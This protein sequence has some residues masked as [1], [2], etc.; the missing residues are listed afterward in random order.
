MAFT[1]T[2]TLTGSTFSGIGLGVIVLT[3]A[4]EAG[5]ASATVA[6]GG[7]GPAPNASLT[8]NGS[9]SA[10][11]WAACDVS[12]SFTSWTLEPNNSTSATGCGV[13]ASPNGETCGTYTGTVTAGTPVTVGASAPSTN[14]TPLSAYEIKASGTLAVDASTPAFSAASA[15]TITSPSFTPPGGVLVAVASGNCSA[16]SGESLAISDTSGL[17]LTWTRRVLSA[18][19]GTSLAWTAIWT[20]SLSTAISG[21]DSVTGTDAGPGPGATPEIKGFPSTARQWIYV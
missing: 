14:Y 6:G 3:G 15:N 2:V 18:T 8:P 9:G 12:G 11:Y 7:G 5:G 19:F 17:G 1:V 13:R 4:T 21:A 10:I 16:T 20:A